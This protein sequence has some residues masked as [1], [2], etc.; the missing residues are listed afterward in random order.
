MRMLFSFLCAIAFIGLLHSTANSQEYEETNRKFFLD[1]YQCGLC[2]SSVK[3]YISPFDYG[4]GKNRTWQENVLNSST[5]KFSSVKES[6]LSLFPAETCAALDLPN[7]TAQFD[8]ISRENIENYARSLCNEWLKCESNKKSNVEQNEEFMEKDPQ[9]G[10]VTTFPDV[11]VSKGMGTRGY[12]KARLSV[13]GTE[14]Y[15]ETYFTYR[16]RFQY[17]WTDKILNTGIV[18][19]NP[20]QTTTFTIAGHDY[21]IFLPNEN[22]GI[23]GLIFADPCFNTDWVNCFYKQDFHTFNHSI[24]LVNAI[25]SHHQQVHYWQILGDNFYD[26]DG[27]SSHN[28]FKNL[29]KA[30][31]ATPLMVV[32][33][34]HDFWVHGNPDRWTIDDQQGNGF[35]QFYGQ[36]TL[37]ATT[38]TTSE[39]YDFAVNPDD[40]SKKGPENLPHGKNF[41]FYNKLGNTAFIGFS[42]AH[43][44]ANQQKHFEEACEWLS[45]ANPDVVLLL[46]HYN[47]A[48]GGCDDQTTVPAV[49]KEIT[50]LPSCAPYAQ[51][52]RYFMG[53]KHCN[54][55]TKKDVGFLIGGQG[56]GNDDVSSTC[57]GEYGFAIVDT[58]QKRFRVYYFAIAKVNEYDHYTKI[59]NCINAN[60][61]IN[62]YHLA[63]LWAD[64]AI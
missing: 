48:A 49:Y 61:I 18:T 62:C 47:T 30:A 25:F 31:R 42:G 28:W 57:G 27:K 16:K 63:Q 37:A 58:T 5:T 29:I 34:N 60:G 41:F 15:N 32:P 52:F 23:R 35:M 59:I 17:R 22:D 21:N 64:V 14:K 38:S 7:E 55:I 50:A 36:D 26:R 11:R 24:E 3:Q 56:M 8:N 1:T 4:E 2:V 46:G 12:K 20:G 39:P 10:D 13:I 45:S 44:Y 40:S 43:A 33:G 19:L 6:C 54:I 53:H 51:K 9:L